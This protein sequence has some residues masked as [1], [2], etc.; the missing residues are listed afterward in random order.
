MT[1]PRALRR[2]GSALWMRM[3]GARVRGHNAVELRDGRLAKRFGEGH[4]GVVDQYVEPA[5]GLDR[6]VCAGLHVGIVQQVAGQGQRHADRARGGFEL[7][8]AAAADGHVRPRRLQARGDLAADAA[9]RARHQSRLSCKHADTSFAKIS[10]SI[11]YHLL[12]QN[13]HRILI[14]IC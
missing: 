9:A 13:Q 10:L 11:S 5:K 4:A 7:F 1:R 14:K 2:C 8:H 3:N 12:R 6:P